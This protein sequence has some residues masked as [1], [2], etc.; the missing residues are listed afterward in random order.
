MPVTR[1]G[2][3]LHFLYDWLEDGDIVCRG[4]AKPLSVS[5][6][7]KPLAFSW[8]DGVLTIPVPY[9]MREMTTSVIEVVEDPGM[10]S[11]RP[12]GLSEEDVRRL[13][14]GTADSVPEESVSAADFADGATVVKSD[15]CWYMRTETPVRVDCLDIGED[16]AHGQFVLAWKAESRVKG[17]WQTVAEGTTIGRR[18]LARF[19]PVEADEFRVTVT[20]ASGPA[21]LRFVALR[22]TNK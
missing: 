1:S 4:I 10:D 20:E 9:S 16:I 19:E 12:A 21:K 7:G 5:L 3:T 18:R 22:Q 13:D 14:S 8:A 11:W 15:C 2:R 6:G 17:K